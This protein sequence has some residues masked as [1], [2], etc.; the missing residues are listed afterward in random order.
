MYVCQSIFNCDNVP[1]DFFPYV[2]PV[3]RSQPRR[4]TINIDKLNCLVKRRAIVIKRELYIHKLR[5]TEW[6]NDHAWRCEF[7]CAG[8]NFGQSAV[9]H[10]FPN[11]LQS[12]EKCNFIVKSKNYFAKLLLLIIRKCLLHVRL[13]YH[14]YRI[15]KSSSPILHRISIINSA[16]INFSNLREYFGII[17]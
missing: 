2:R 12:A 8:C 10:K 9:L 3:H 17:F 14:I 16:L 5:V 15:G 4:Q 13:F 6:H 7:E 1:A 11:F